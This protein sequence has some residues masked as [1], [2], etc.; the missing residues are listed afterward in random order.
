[1]LKPAKPHSFCIVRAEPMRKA[2][3]SLISRFEKFE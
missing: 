2:L 1:M 3:A